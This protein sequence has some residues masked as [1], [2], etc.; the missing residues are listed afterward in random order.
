LHYNRQQRP[1]LR[2]SFAGMH[3]YAQ[4]EAKEHCENARVTQEGAQHFI[5]DL[6]KQL[7]ERK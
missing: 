6:K 3:Q 4:A 5:D 2:S 7:A 1:N